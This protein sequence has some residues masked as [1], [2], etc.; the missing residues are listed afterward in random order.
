MAT[1]E[2]QIRQDTFV[3]I[4][5]AELVRVQVPGAVVDQLIST[6]KQ[7]LN[8][9]LLIE[10]IEFPEI[11]VVDSTPSISSDKLPLGT[12]NL[13]VRVK[14]DVYLTTYANAKAAGHLGIPATLPPQETT[15]WIRF[16]LTHGKQ[17]FYAVVDSTQDGFNFS[18]TIPL[19]IP[20]PLDVTFWQTAIFNRDGVVAIRIGT[21]VEDTTT[22]R[23]AFL[24]WWGGNRLGS[25]VWGAFIS[26]D[27]F[28]HELDHLVYGAA[29]S[30]TSTSKDPKIN[31]DSHDS[32]WA[33]RQHF[34]EADLDLV[35]VDAG[36]FDTDVSFEISVR[37]QPQSTSPTAIKFN[38]RVEWD[39]PDEV[40]DAL[41][42]MARNVF[43]DQTEV[44]SGD[45]FV[46]FTVTK[47]LNNVY[48]PSFSMSITNSW[49]DDSGLVIL[50]NATARPRPTADWIVTNPHW[51]I[52]GD[53]H[54]KTVGIRFEPASVLL[55]G[56]D[57]YLELRLLEAIS[58]PMLFWDPTETRSRLG[59]QPITCEV[60]LT[61]SGRLLGDVP[62]GIPV[63]AF[64]YT[65][66]G[67]RWVDFGLVPVRP[68]EDEKELLRL[69][70]N[71]I[72]Q[73]MAISDRWGMG[74]MNWKWLVD[75]PDLRVDFGYKPVQEWL[76]M[77]SGMQEGKTVELFAVNADG[78]RR[79]LGAV[80]VK[81]GALLLHNII[82]E[83]KETLEIRTE[84]GLSSQAPRVMRRWIVPTQVVPVSKSVGTFTL[85]GPQL[86]VS[87]RD[88][89]SENLSLEN[90]ANTKREGMHVSE[91]QNINSPAEL[92]VD[93]AE[94]SHHFYMRSS[95]HSIL[96][97]S[98]SI[99]LVGGR[100][101][102][103]GVAGRFQPALDPVA[104][105]IPSAT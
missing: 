22:G 32:R 102:I 70:I 14:I 5:R 45:D 23:D 48:A 28:S 31:I 2:F 52:G 42:G 12:V 75:P 81:G 89:S 95:P 39:A 79:A 18:G 94:D 40:N 104:P 56:S 92:K 26:G 101:I 20:M 61:P 36:L 103:L 68:V 4:I 1:I 72:S 78:Q 33:T 17:L 29:Q 27:V 53:C 62:D 19:Q 60:A 85:N 83:F 69:T 65:N 105:T 59:I 86:S 13:F 47:Y 90:K 97:S 38:T 63:S 96:K 41:S 71:L 35:A 84:S 24:N 88:G 6:G 67:V 82:T 44:G 57:P 77:G 25:A 91:Q 73:C 80:R 3:D 43:G 9:E 58:S 30:F 74:V 93:M 11:T 21:D 49:V 100:N 37:S 46:E 98:G 99:A 64:L 54:S 34:A 16:E 66:V 10:R 7:L 51:R 55:V 87:Y 15:A 76:L 8:Q 50:G